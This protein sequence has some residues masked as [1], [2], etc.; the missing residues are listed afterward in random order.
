[1]NKWYLLVLMLKLEC[2]EQGDNEGWSEDD[3]RCVYVSKS[4]EEKIFDPLGIDQ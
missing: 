1:M 3:Q 4:F 2:V